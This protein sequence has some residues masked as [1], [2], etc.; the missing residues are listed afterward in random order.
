MS[1]S[2]IET[3][4]TLLRLGSESL[5]NFSNNLNQNQRVTLQTRELVIPAKPDRPE[6]MMHGRRTAGLVAKRL[7]RS[8]HRFVA[9]C[10]P[11][12][13][14]RDSLVS[15]PVAAAALGGGMR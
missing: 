3:F 4:P 5:I 11:G 8:H 2:L 13:E 9:R 7:G 15:T 1:K 12:Q 14:G 6:F 10:L